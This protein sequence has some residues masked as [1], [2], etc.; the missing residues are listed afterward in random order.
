M[1]VFTGF[2]DTRT[3]LRKAFQ[4]AAEILQM[5]NGNG[6]SLHLDRGIKFSKVEGNRR[7]SLAPAPRV[8]MTLPLSFP[9][10]GVD[11][12]VFSIFISS[13]LLLLGRPQPHRLVDI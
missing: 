5:R 11:S 10:S 7:V 8:T 13:I 3:E 1:A 6:G 4:K 9:L 2:S 12:L